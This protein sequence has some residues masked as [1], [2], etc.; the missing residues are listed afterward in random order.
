MKKLLLLCTAVCALL[1]VAVPAASAD[2]ATASSKAHS[3]A[4]KTLSAS[5]LSSQV[6]KTNASIKGIG[7]A[8]AFFTGQN[9]ARKTENASTAATIAAIVPVVTKALTDLQSGLLALKDGLEKA[10]KGL[11][12]LSAAVQGPNIAGQLGAAGTAAPGAA[13]T[14]TPD[15]LPA[16]TVYRQIVISGAALGP[17]PAGSPV[18]ARTWVKTVPPGTAAPA[19]NTWSCT[20]AGGNT[21]LGV[22]GGAVTCTTAP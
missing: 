5:A 12:D 16:G 3:A 22:P 7:K 9:N 8:I 19:T 15:T 17:I 14:A 2:P 11:T 6:R 1:V 4:G 13:N 10:G 18:G 21:Q 20:G